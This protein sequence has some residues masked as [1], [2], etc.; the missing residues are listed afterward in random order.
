MNSPS[1]RND[2]SLNQTNLADNQDE[3]E[4]I[5]PNCW[6]DIKLSSDRYILQNLIGQGTYGCVYSAQDL[7]TGKKIAVKFFSNIE[8]EFGISEH[9]FRELHILKRLSGSSPYIIELIEVCTTYFELA[10]QPI[11]NNNNVADNT[12]SNNTRAHH[13][14]ISF[15][16]LYDKSIYVVLAYYPDSLYGWLYNIK[17]RKLTIHTIQIFIYQLLKALEIV[18]KNKIIHRDIKPPNI[19]VAEN[20]THLIL[21]DF[22]MARYNFS[23]THNATKT[24]DNVITIQ[25]RP[26]EVLLGSSYYSS[27]VDIWS[28]GCV[29]SELLHFYDH[30]PTGPYPLLL[31]PETDTERQIKIILKTL[32]TPTPS[33]YPL[34]H[35]KYTI[36]QSFTRPLPWSNWFPDNYKKIPVAAYDLLTKMLQINPDNRWTCQQ[37]LSHSFFANL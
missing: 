3:I 19:L 13:R 31:F 32:G 33:E 23:S 2:N 29:F 6:S 25:Y 1:S 4:W 16:S 17:G 14:Q 7:T 12:N 36:R 28:L 9:T 27:A 34:L 10:D 26:I 15:E 8:G 37:L 30:T 21:T 5:S 24:P 11:N 35:D 22:G 20:D 18:H